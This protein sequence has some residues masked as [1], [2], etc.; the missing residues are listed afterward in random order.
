MTGRLVGPPYPRVVVGYSGL[1][2]SAEHHRWSFPGASAAEQRHF[3]GY[4]AAAAVFVDGHLV[5]ACQQE[6][7][8]GR[9]FDHAFPGT[10]VHQCLRLAGLSI[11]D[12]DAVAHNFD[13][14][15]LR[16][17]YARNPLAVDR[18]DAVLDPC[19]QGRWFG[20]HF[21]HVPP[22]FP[23]RHHIAHATYAVAAAGRDRLTVV[24]ADGLG[25]TDALT[26]FAY[27]DGRLERVR[28]WPWRA[29]LG[30]YYSLVTQ[31]LGWLANSD[32]YKVMGLAA[33]GDPDRYRQIFDDAVVLR[34]D[35]GV[36]VT[37]LGLPDEPALRGLHRPAS[38]W[39][40]DHL[41][42]TRMPNVSVEQRH[43]DVAA[44]AQQRLEQALRHV[45]TAAVTETGIGDVAFGGGVAL[46]CLAVGRLAGRACD[47]L[48]VP[49]APGDDGT[50]IG[51]A[52]AV[53]D[54]DAASASWPPLP[55]LGPA[56]KAPIALAN[57]SDHIA[58]VADPQV[59]AHVGAQVLA[60]GAVV[61]WA[62]GPME[63][64]PRALGNRSIFADPRTK[65]SR[66]RVNRAIKQREN[67]RPLAP[68]VKAEAAPRYFDLPPAQLRHMTAVA[69]ARPTALHDVPAVVHADGTARVQIV[70]RA[71]HAVLWHLLDG[72]E[73]LTGVPVLLNTSLNINGRP[74][75]CTAEDAVA[76]YE[77]GA[78]D[79]L[80]VDNHILATTAWRPR[81]MDALRRTVTGA[82]RQ[83][84][85]SRGEV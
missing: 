1:H 15:G 72:F 82:E 50:A 10:A 37:F 69:R 34:D 29:S 77:A 40:I 78:L 54:L 27:H 58:A 84:R 41:G 55:L 7:W 43:A 71:E 31:H 19:L 12:V 67:F 65:A 4:D 53:L 17:L 83:P 45:I 36:D 79:L 85:T 33:Y 66:E 6:R 60:A 46:N 16:K 73:E 38:A 59:R 30:L 22:F 18:Y 3:Q 28:S 11:T 52:L 13:H 62:H 81:V 63:F 57:R 76:T 5:A 23:V 75:A 14:G 21:G 68:V 20:E 47:T 44:A 42:T 8:S 24:I 9:K 48:L 26:V 49:P 51:A 80:V 64:G 2:G 35:G 39:L 25:E 70:H 32:E 61:G 74:M 56:P